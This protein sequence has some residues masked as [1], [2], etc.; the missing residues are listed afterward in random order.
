VVGVD[1]DKETENTTV[2]QIAEKKDNTTIL[3]LAKP[4]ICC[5]NHRFCNRLKPVV[6][7]D[8]ILI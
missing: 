1:I 5:R 2:D 3:I 6:L 4:V 7:A 8:F